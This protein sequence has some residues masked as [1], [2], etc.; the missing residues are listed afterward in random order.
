MKYCAV[1]TKTDEAIE[2]E[3]PDLA[4]CVTFGYTQKEAYEMAVDA[5]HCWLEAAEPQFIKKPSPKDKIEKRFNGLNAYTLEI[6][7]NS[8]LVKERNFEFANA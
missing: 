1:F 5:L 7:V 8:K 6:P 2:V 3:F 4:C